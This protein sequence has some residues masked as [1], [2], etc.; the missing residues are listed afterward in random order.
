MNIDRHIVVT[1]AIPQEELLFFKDEGEWERERE[2]ERERYCRL[3]FQPYRNML[4]IQLRQ[5]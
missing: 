1:Q 4:P 2:R 5:N 3:I